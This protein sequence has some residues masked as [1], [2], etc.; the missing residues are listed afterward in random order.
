MTS[1]VLARFKKYLRLLSQGARIVLK[2]KEKCNQQLCFCNSVSSED[3][4][5]LALFDEFPLLELRLRLLVFAQP[6]LPEEKLRLDM[7]RAAELC[8]ILA[9]VE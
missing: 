7:A 8:D 6:L 9:P 3:Y 4:S 5:G 2:I 1:N